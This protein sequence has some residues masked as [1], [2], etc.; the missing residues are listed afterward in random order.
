M[1]FDGQAEQFDDVAGLPPD[2]GRRIAQVI[3]ELGG[4]TATDAILDV[5]AGTGVI[6]LHLATRSSRYLGL[7]QSVRMLEVFRQKLDPWPQHLLLVQA[8]SDRP[9][10]IGDRALAVVFASRVVHH[11]VLPHFVTEVQR[12][13]RP[14]GCL[15]LGRVVRAADSL[16]SRLQRRKRALLAEHGIGARMGGQ[17]IQQIVTICGAQGATALSPAIAAQWTRTMTARQLLMAWRGKPRL[18]SSAAGNNLSSELRD[19][20]LNALNIWALQEF[21]DLDRPEEFVEEYVLQ[22]VRLP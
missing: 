6:G 7:D 19:G 15:L 9:W 11:L 18:N 2:A 4:C 21:G 14:G 12:V 20:L 10:P 22:A 17:A 5:G 16:P 13:C 8:D 3:W 1:W